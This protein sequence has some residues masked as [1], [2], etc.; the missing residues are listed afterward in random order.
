M[1]YAANGTSVRRN[2]P[3][4]TP[5][6]HELFMPSEAELLAIDKT[7]A[8]AKASGAIFRF[9]QHRALQDQINERSAA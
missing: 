7:Y 3:F 6:E 1:S 4:L 2:A 8:I 9:E 5:A